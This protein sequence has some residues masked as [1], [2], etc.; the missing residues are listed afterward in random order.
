ME[1]TLDLD[2]I[3]VATRI[4]EFRKKHPEGSLQQKSVEFIEFGGKS[5]VIYIAEA[6]RHPDDSRP[7]VGSAW[8][9]VPGQTEKTL[10]SELQNAET[11]AW[12]RALVAVLAADTRKGVASAEEVRNVTA[13]PTNTT[14]L[15]PFDTTALIVYAKT[16]PTTVEVEQLWHALTGF[17][18]NVRD[19]VAQ[20]ARTKNVEEKKDDHLTP[21]TT[22]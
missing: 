17:P 10:D 3:P 7:G 6:Y 22:E 21:A 2:Y 8:Q 11:A 15:K 19:A 12:G 1:S 13:K 16:L 18:Q 14:V 5:W 9:Q 20:I 4:A